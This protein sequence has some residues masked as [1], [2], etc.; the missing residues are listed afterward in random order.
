M[1]A[2]ATETKEVMI[3]SWIN[4]EER[5]TG[6]IEI[7]LR[8]RELSEAVSLLFFYMISKSRHHRLPTIGLIR[9]AR[10][11][12]Q[13]DS[14]DFTPINFHGRMEEND[15]NSKR[16]DQYL[17]KSG[18]LMQQLFIR[19]ECLLAAETVE[20]ARLATHLESVCKE[21]RG[22]QEA[23]REW[24]RSSSLCVENLHASQGLQLFMKL[25]EVVCEGLKEGNE[26]Q[27]I[28]LESY[29]FLLSVDFRKDLKFTG[30]YGCL[31]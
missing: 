7:H 4:A 16:Y 24:M 13:G 8:S 25:V 30:S 23:C 15:C 5:M 3:L 18:S 27:V 14:F 19:K 17:N 11:L 2:Q 29:R 6:Q 28:S 10:E 20:W 1:R 22:V 21:L 31:E 26:K 9:K 12:W